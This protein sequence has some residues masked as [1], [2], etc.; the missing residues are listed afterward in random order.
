MADSDIEDELLLLLI[1]HRRRMQRQQQ[2]LWV[3][4]IMQHRKEHGE[5]HQLAFFSTSEI[6][7]SSMMNID[8]ND[9]PRKSTCSPD[10]ICKQ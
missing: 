5:F 2:R 4:E 7:F 8:D 10:I 3:H 9:G 6:N 1:I